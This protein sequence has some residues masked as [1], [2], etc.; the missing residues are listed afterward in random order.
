MVALENKDCKNDIKA[1]DLT[2]IDRPS[3]SINNTSVAQ[4]TVNHNNSR[5]CKHQRVTSEEICNVC[6]QSSVNHE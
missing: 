1:L 6:Q 2:K 4:T 3:T 5:S